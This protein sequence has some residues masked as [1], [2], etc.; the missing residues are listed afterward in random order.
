MLKHVKQYFKIF[1]TGY[2]GSMQP[3]CVVIYRDKKLYQMKYL[4]KHTIFQNNL[5]KLCISGKFEQEPF[6]IDI[7]ND[8]EDSLIFNAVN[9]MTNDGYFVSGS[10]KTSNDCSYSVKYHAISSYI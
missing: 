1:T 2:T 7:E 4:S 6:I 10:V 5:Q 8:N 3:G 9:Y